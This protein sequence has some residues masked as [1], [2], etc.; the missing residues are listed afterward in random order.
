MT[1]KLLSADDLAQLRH[2]Y[3]ER[4]G[5]VSILLDHIEALSALAADVL[6]ESGSIGEHSVENATA[7]CPLCDALVALANGLSIGRLAHSPPAAP[8][9]IDGRDE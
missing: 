6:A 7:G 1:S 5:D 9:P 2:I 4:T 8:P 3:G